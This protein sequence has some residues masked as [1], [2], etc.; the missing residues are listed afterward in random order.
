MTWWHLW[1][2]HHGSEPLREFTPFTRWMQTQRHNSC[3]PS[4]QAKQLRLWV[5]RWAATIHIH[6]RHCYYYSA[7]NWYAFY[8][9]TEGRRPS[10]PRHCSKC[11]QPVPKAV[12]RI[13]RHDK[14][15][16]P[17]WDSNSG[18]LAPQS[19]ALTA[20]PLRPAD[21]PQISWNLPGCVMLLTIE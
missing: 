19:N 4:D 21:V 3:Q 12:N 2:C 13:G 8:P 10:Q 20:R 15:N 1:C 11:V 5:R 18:P 17:R 6:Y 14:H 16:R 9:L 7:R